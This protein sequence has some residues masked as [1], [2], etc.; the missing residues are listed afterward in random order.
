MGRFSSLANVRT[1]QG[2]L[3]FLAGDYD[4]EL[5]EVKLIDT[6]KGQEA[7]IISGKVLTSTNPD[8][9]P[10]CKPSQVMVLKTEILETVMSNIKQFAGAALGIEDPDDY[11]P[12]EGKTLEEFWDE[13]LEAIVSDEQPLKGV[14]IHLN[15]SMIK[16]REGK[17]F[18]KHVWTHI[19]E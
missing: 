19:P 18:S 15:V 7:F 17:D 3:Y 1:N 11:E 4:V 14:K 10:G 6:R 8:R 9:A 13:T 5:D 16:T 12:E 2:G